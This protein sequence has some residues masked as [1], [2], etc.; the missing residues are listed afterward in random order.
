MVGADGSTELISCLT[1]YLITLISINKLKQ[2]NLVEHLEDI[3]FGNHTYAAVQ[4]LVY[5]C[6]SHDMGKLFLNFCAKHLIRVE[7]QQ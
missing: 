3:I 7:Q 1:Y 2:E 6:A 4:T 5:F